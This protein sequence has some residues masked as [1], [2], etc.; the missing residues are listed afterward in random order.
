[1]AMSC[2]TGG[3]E[4]TGCGACRETEEE[5]ALYNC[6]NCNEDIYEGDMY[7]EVAG[8]IYCENCVKWLEA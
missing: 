1:M 3:R 8:D 5:K 4:C 7:Y 6:I 2:V